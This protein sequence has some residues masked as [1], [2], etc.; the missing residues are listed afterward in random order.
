MDVAESVRS[1][2]MLMQQFGYTSDEAY[3]LII[4]GA[5]NGLNK[6]DDLLDTINEYSVHF[7]QIGLDREVHSQWIN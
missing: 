1:A 4:Q 3:N 7:K 2:N 5:Q 6:N